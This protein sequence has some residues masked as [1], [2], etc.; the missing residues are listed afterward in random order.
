VR[1]DFSC[2]ASKPDHWYSTYVYSSPPHFFKIKKMERSGALTLGHFLVYA[3]ILGKLAQRPG[4]L[5][6]RRTMWSAQPGLIRP[7]WAFGLS[8]L[9]FSFWDRQLNS[10]R[11]RRADVHPRIA[12][13]AVLRIKSW[14]YCGVTCNRKKWDQGS[15]DLSHPSWPPLFHPH[16]GRQ[17]QYL[18]VE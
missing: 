8:F 3:Q 18:Y 11:A 1:I 13:F 10:A 12:H 9:P 2:Y 6:D 14:V 4:R 15:L 7:Q 17:I 5:D 16:V